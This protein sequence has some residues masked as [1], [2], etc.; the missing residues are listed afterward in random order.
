MANTI[1]QKDI[2][3]TVWKACDT[4]RGVIDPSQYKDYIL[5]M[6]FLKYVSDVNK[7]K[8]TQ[9]LE[10]Y[11]GDIDRT[12]RAMKM[13]RFMVP[14]N[15]SFEYL[16]EHRSE[17]NLGELIDIAL[18]DLEEANREK[19]S[20]ED[21]S[22]IFRNISFNSSNLGETKDKNSRLKYLLNDFSELDLAP[23]HLQNNDIIGDAYEFLIANFAS[24]AGKKA[25]EFFTPS[26]VSTLLAKLTKSKIGAKI[27]DPTS[28]SGSLL[29]KAG[30]EVGSDNF[31]LYGQE[32]NGSTWALAVMN[33]FLHGFDSA[34]IRWGDTIR[35]PKLK[36]GDELMK[37]DTVVANPPFSLDK[38]GADTAESDKYNRFWRGIPPKSKG[39]WAFITHMIE[40]IN[41]TGKVGVVVPHGVLFRGSSEGK[42]RQKTIEENILEAVIG[43]PANLFFGTGIP[44]AILVFN[45]AK[46]NNKKVLF[47]D[48]S[49]HYDSG[50][51]QNKLNESHIMHIVETYRQFN[52]GKLKLGVFEEKFSYVATFEEIKENDFNLNIPRYVDTFEEEAEVDIVKVQSEIEQLEKEL[53]TVQQEMKKYLTELYKN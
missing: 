18:S 5:T 33:M 11:K 34:T 4:F 10:K 52:E 29:I 46:D 20:S 25:G 15:S 19:L 50:K 44:A 47:I 26:E 13:E 35:N 43:L 45:K 9:Y 16:Y 27:C 6:L 30:R 53:V 8:R 12:E 31:S 42:I 24:D 23:S 41:E 39:D 3:Q 7:E 28:G 21:G 37:F 48:S 40:T 2:N 51:N 49:Q 36:E 22:G 1:N 32:A 14:N 38:W 17:V